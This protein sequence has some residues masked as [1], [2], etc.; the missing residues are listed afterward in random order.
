MLK[1]ILAAL[2]LSASLSGCVV[3]DVVEGFRQFGGK[4]PSKYAEWRGNQTLK[5]QKP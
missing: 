2:V 4:P 5:R 1:L 3:L